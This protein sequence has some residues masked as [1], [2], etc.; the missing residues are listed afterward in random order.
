MRTCAS[1]TTDQFRLHPRLQKCNSACNSVNSLDN[2]LNSQQH[3]YSSSTIYSTAYNDTND[4]IAYKANNNPQ[5]YPFC[6]HTVCLESFAVLSRK[7][8][9][10]V[11][12]W[13]GFQYKSTFH[14]Y[15]CFK[16]FVITLTVIVQAI[17]IHLRTER[18]FA[19]VL[20]FAI[21]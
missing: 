3:Y 11:L 19:N 8:N 4:Y 5:N 21:Y 20:P 6:F 15:S 17:I 18:L 7:F 2:H 1:D 12:V 16:S 13:F 9:C 10:M 14:T